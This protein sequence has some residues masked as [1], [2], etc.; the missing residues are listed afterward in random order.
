MWTKFLESVQGTE[1]K[2]QELQKDTWCWSL[3]QASITYLAMS[4]H[5]SIQ[6]FFCK[7][8]LT[9]LTFEA[10]VWVSHTIYELINIFMKLNKPRPCYIILVPFNVPSAL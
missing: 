4:K 5:F 10:T 3:L 7:V 2:E 6:A 1:S 8:E 9:V